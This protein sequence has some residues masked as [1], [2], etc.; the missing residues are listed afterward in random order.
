LPEPEDYGE[1]DGTE[2]G[3]GASV[4]VACDAALVLEAAEG[5]LDAVAVERLVV[6]NGLFP[7]LLGR[8]WTTNDT[9][10]CT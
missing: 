2:D 10:F 4:V 6:R 3:G 1:G 9:A 8:G 7:V 5:Y